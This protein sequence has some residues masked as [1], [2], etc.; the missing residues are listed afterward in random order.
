[1]E[2]SYY[3]FLKD[4]DLNNP[5][6]LYDNYSVGV[7]ESV[8][9]DPTL[10]IPPVEDIPI[11]DWL[12]EVKRIMTDIIGFDT[13]LFY[14]MLAANAYYKQFIE[15]T[16]PLSKI[17]KEN[18][19]KYFKNQSFVDILFAENEKII[20]IAAITS[21]LKINETPA[22]SKE[23]L[24]NVII[25]KYK[26]KVV[27]V[28]FWATWCAPCLDAMKKSR[29]LKKEMMDKDVVFVYMANVS[30]PEELWEKKIRG[31]G[32][33]HYYLNREEWEYLLDSYDFSGIPTYLFYDSTGVL[34]NK[35][36]GYPGTDEMRK[37]IGEL[38][39]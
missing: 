36:V 1:M 32:G 5:K 10:N 26:G 25:S 15:E 21:S 14:D 27:V 4:F 24:M 18:I 20:K 8:L 6:M 23:E 2:V 3:T 37:M 35:I 13:G 38:L 30:S 19:Q 39:P 33:E 29:E 34:K 31:I 7:L 9:S 28:D 17:Q 16:K 22:V 12:Q 11:N